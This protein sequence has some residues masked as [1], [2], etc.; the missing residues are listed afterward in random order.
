MQAHAC[1]LKHGHCKCVYCVTSRNLEGKNDSTPTSLG[2]RS[3]QDV[4]AS[5]EHHWKILPPDVKPFLLQRPRSFVDFANFWSQP[6]RIENAKGDCALSISG[7]CWFL[8]LNYMFLDR[9]VEAQTLMLQG[10]FMQECLRRRIEDIALIWN[11]TSILH[12]PLY[13]ET[14]LAT[15]TK[16][17]MQSHLNRQLPPDYIRRMS[18]AYQVSGKN[19]SHSIVGD[20][21]NF[22]SNEWNGASSPSAASAR[23]QEKGTNNA[24][25]EVVLRNSDTNEERTVTIEMSATLK[26]I[27]NNYADQQGVSLRSLRFTH[28]GKILF[29]SFAA[30]KTA[31]QLGINNNDTIHISSTS[32][33]TPQVTSSSVRSQKKI[34]LKRYSSNANKKSKGKSSRKRTTATVHVATT[35]IVSYEED[36]IEHS[37]QLSRVFEEAQPLLKSI[38]Q[39]LNSLNI[40]R[41]LPKKRSSKKK[42]KAAV[43]PILNSSTI[44]IEGKAGKSH[45]AVQVGESCNLYK[46][47]KRPAMS[48]K[49]QQPIIADLH[50]LTKEEALCKLDSSLP[51]W[52]DIA[53]KGSYP[54]VIPVNIVCGCGS[55]VLSEVVENWV[56]QNASVANA[57]KRLHVA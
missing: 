8:A 33:T 41:T 39:E 21:I 13:E 14:C 32:S 37:K 54:F 45:F 35:A 48:P 17:S 20:Y 40:E 55:Q 34:G 4:L 22:I 56:R 50:G 24:S 6:N 30:N 16:Q 36:K 15:Q 19:R 11:G 23:H 38:R 2:H 26:S 44:G 3:T 51:Q 27:F 9:L 42:S 12:F 46:T 10:S 57:P 53:M 52:I 29:L 25:I 1:N 47:T 43:A 31:E 18:F 28:A 7:S 49:Q 5:I